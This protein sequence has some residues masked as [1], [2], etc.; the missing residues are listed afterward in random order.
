M[1][2]PQT[3]PAFR[4]NTVANE[5]LMRPR[6]RPAL[7]PEGEP[8]R[9][10]EPIFPQVPDDQRLNDRQYHGINRD[11]CIKAW[12]APFFKSRWYRARL[13]P[14]S[15]P[16]MPSAI[17]SGPHHAAGGRKVSTRKKP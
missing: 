17:N 9:L 7:T 1:A 12:A 3:A 5:E 11:R 6:M 4:L 8:Q 13:M 2:S 10:P 15:A 14:T 16:A